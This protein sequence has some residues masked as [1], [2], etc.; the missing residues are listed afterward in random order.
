MR[1][2]LGYCRKFV[3]YNSTLFFRILFL[4]KEYVGLNHEVFLV[5]A[6]PTV[7]PAYVRHGS[8]TSIK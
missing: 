6:S 5:T 8:V 3:H 1:T 4:F 7:H 2:I